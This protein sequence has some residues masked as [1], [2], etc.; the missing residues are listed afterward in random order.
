MNVARKAL[1]LWGLDAADVTLIAAR[2][3]SVYR[4]DHATGRFALRLHRPG[5]RTDEQ[6]AAELEWMAWIARSGLSLPVPRASVNGSLLQ[7][8]EGVQ[9]DVLSWLSGETLDAMLTTTDDGERSQLSHGLGRNMAKLHTA[10]DAWPGATACERPAWDVDGLLG[11]APLWDRFW[12]NPGLSAGERDLLCTFRAEARSVLEATSETLDYGLI[13]ADLVPANVMV[14]Q[15][16][17]HFIDFDDGGFGFRLFDV[18]TAL[19][20]HRALSDFHCLKS[21]MI[22]GYRSQRPLDTANLD[23]FLALRAMTYVGWNITRFDEDSTRSRNARFI[24]QAVELSA[25][26]LDPGCSANNPPERSD[27]LSRK[28]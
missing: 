10:S 7:I 21:A 13:H 15:G 25:A 18:A 4:V 27:G 12:E 3:N 8:V 6:L 5:Y 16:K 9:I 17:L 23:L 11:D 28:D 26:Y 2:E 22:E 20:K 24:A 19:F 14:D 1:P